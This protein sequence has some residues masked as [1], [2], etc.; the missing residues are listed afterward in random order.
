MWAKPNQLT[1]AGTARPLRVAYLIDTDDC[2]DQLLDR[3]FAEAYGRW[4][5]RRT[6]IIPAK[7]DGID[8]RYNPRRVRRA[9]ERILA[10]RSDKPWRCSSRK[11]HRSQRR[12]DQHAA[13]AVEA[14]ERRSDVQQWNRVGQACA[15]VHSLRADGREVGP[16][17]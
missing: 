2:P 3:I 14:T 5:G 17:H 8:E 4:G 12:A 11:K 7:P 15:G 9:H 13:Q 10:R 6:L 16:L 1:T